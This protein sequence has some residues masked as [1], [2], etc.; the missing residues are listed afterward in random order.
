MKNNHA[1]QK[2]HKTKIIKEDSDDIFGVNN[3]IEEPIHT[4]YNDSSNNN[5]D[6]YGGT[7]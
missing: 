4:S 1:P 5:D 3:N 7:F 6:I 2:K